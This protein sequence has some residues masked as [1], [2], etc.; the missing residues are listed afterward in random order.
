MQKIEITNRDEK[1]T[2]LTLDS[3]MFELFSFT[4]KIGYNFKNQL[5]KR[6][7]HNQLTIFLK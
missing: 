2:D 1:L 4:K 6:I 3:P 5:F 7:L